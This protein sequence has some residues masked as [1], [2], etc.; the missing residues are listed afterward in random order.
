MAH[1]DD[2]DGKLPLLTAGGRLREARIAAG[3]EL[4]EIAA[5]TRVSK[6][7]LAVIEE[8]RY[9]DLASRTYAIG[10]SKTFARAIG[11]DEESIAAGVRSEMARQAELQPRPLRTEHF[12]PGD[13]ARVP[14]SSLAWIAGLGAVALFVLLFLFW[15]SF[16]D[17]AGEM[18]DLVTDEVR[19]VSAPKASPGVPAPV[20]ATAPVRLTAL[21]NGVWIKITDAAGA[22]LFQKEL[23]LGEAYTLP[24]D[25]RGAILATARPDALQVMVG[26]RNLG[27]LRPA[28]EIMR[29]V[30]LAPVDLMTPRAS[31]PAASTSPVP[32]AAASPSPPARPLG[33]GA[34]T[35]TD[36]VG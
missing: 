30:S 21:E 10:F 14:P 8:D 25:A 12:E 19:A 34:E 33:A 5:R 22:Q 36:S 20:A 13:P 29:G 16:V 24:S 6:R 26:T 2:E 18:P 27:P 15:R 23:A 17:P 35:S 3:L 7:H 11:I 9:S 1:D 32:N 28:P 31:A 4:E